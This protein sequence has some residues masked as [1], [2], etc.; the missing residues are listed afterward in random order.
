MRVEP[1]PSQAPALAF[2]REQHISG[3]RPGYYKIVDM[4]NQTNQHSI[5]DKAE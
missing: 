1:N 5:L 3:G 2:K 4:D